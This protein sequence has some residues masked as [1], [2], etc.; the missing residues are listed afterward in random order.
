[1]KPH[2]LHKARGAVTNP[3]GRFESMRHEAFDDGWVRT[4]DEE[5][6]AVRTQL[7]PDTARSVI[8]Y[9]DSPDIP[10]DRSIN[11]YRGCEHGCIYCFARP[12]H[13]YLGLSAGLDFETKLF[14]KQ[15]AV[16]LL[17]A[18]LKNPRYR[19]QPIAFGINTDAYQP[20]ERELKLSRS[21]LE[22]LLRYRHPLSLITKSRLILRDIDLLRE[23]AQRNLV[24][25]MI[26]ITSLE[27][28]VKSALEP[29]AAAPAVRLE[30]I[31]ELSA[32]E[33]PVG[34]MVAP[35]IPFITDNEME[36]ILEAAYQ[37]GA[38]DA[39]YVLLRLPHEV[40]ELFHDWMR[41]HYP[42]K[43]E[44]VMSLLRQS[45]GG[46]EYDA[47]WGTRMRGTGQ[48]AELLAQR[49][50]KAYHALGYG[51]RSMPGLDISQ[52]KVEEEASGQ[53]RMD[54]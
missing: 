9:N 37:A 20:V 11:P 8:N 31:R 12:S 19:C 47:Q 49:F 50:R 48:Y 15:D 27:T 5:G 13:A 25:V 23:L 40:K 53:L 45:H 36:S 34:V 10:F 22:V 38:R 24:S 35:V 46:K 52:F 4:E 33:V 43:A 51:E 1:M 39:G 21:L 29:R 54:L 28:G 30:I 6:K 18:E 32:A 7:L 26:S 14:Y 3:D 42:Q 2:V 44:H 17:E 16:Q 41:V